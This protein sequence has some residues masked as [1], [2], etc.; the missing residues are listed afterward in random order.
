MKYRRTARIAL[1]L[2][3][4][5]LLPFAA[6]PALAQGGRTVSFDI[7]GQSLRSAIQA[8]ATASGESI[9]APGELLDNLTAPDLHGRHSVRQALDIVLAGSGLRA[10]RAGSTFIIE[11]TPAG[12]S[13]T[14]ADAATAG[15]VIVTGTRIR[16]APVASPVI[17]LTGERQ[18]RWAR[19]KA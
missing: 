10:R 13:V 4:T 7:A 14:V 8:I 5:N 3:A 1:S 11:R 19:Q 2:A 9:V 18:Q 17:R 15:E 12:E 6:M 16:G